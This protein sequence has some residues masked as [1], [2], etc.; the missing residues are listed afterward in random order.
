[1][2]LMLFEPGFV[3]MLEASGNL[4]HMQHM[5]DGIWIHALHRRLFRPNAIIA[6]VQAH[7]CQVHAVVFGSCCTQLV[8]EDDHQKQHAFKGSTVSS[9]EPSVSQDLRTPTSRS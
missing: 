2:L 9:L 3:A 1:M 6:Q 5:P 7:V 8:E 4:V